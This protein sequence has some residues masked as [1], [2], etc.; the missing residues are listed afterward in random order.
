[1]SPLKAPASL[2]Q[3]TRQRKTLVSGRD[4]SGGRLS[5]Q[6]TFADAF[7]GTP[8]DFLQTGMDPGTISPQTRA[9]TAR[10]PNRH[11]GRRSK[12]APPPFRVS[13]PA[14]FAGVIGDVYAFGNLGTPARDVFAGA[15][16]LQM[17][18][19]PGARGALTDF[20]PEA[21]HISPQECARA[22]GGGMEPQPARW[23]A[24]HGCFVASM[25]FLAR[26]AAAAR[27]A[28]NVRR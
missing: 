22:G 10:M 12:D 17:N 26:R 5:E 14:R 1:M 7:S 8:T 16:S 11:G 20:L 9:G 13:G 25:F 23:A 6:Q 15:L 24:E 4:L 18:T 27:A 3:N 19:L 21:I 2:R 28:T